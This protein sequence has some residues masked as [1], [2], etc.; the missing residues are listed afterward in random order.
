MIKFIIVGLNTTV[1]GTLL[2][3]LLLS[4]LKHLGIEIISPSVIMIMSYII[5]L[6]SYFIIYSLY[7][8]TYEQK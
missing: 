4:A 6:F 2:T 5:A 1:L 3:I 7:V 8:R